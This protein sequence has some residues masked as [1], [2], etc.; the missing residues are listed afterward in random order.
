MTRLNHQTSQPLLKASFI[1]FVP[2]A[3]HLYC[4][5]KTTLIFHRKPPLPPESGRQ[6]RRS[7][8]CKHA[9]APD[10]VDLPQSLLILSL[11]LPFPANLGIFVGPDALHMLSC[12]PFAAKFQPEWN[13]GRFR[14]PKPVLFVGNPRDMEQRAFQPFQPGSFGGQI[15]QIWNWGRFLLY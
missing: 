12:L 1:S 10:L 14:P 7:G 6:F 8:C 5:D 3:G 11:A 15:H 9:C 4:G 13:W 2:V